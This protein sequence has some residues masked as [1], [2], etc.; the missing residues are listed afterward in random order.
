MK[1]QK[2]S[3]RK[4]GDPNYEK[5]VKWVLIVPQ[6]RIEQLGWK[7]GMELKEEIRKNSLHIT[8]FALNELNNHQESILF[9]EFKKSI[10]NILERHPAGLTWSQIRDKLNLPQKYPNNKWVRKLE[11]EI[12]LRRIRKGSELFW[13]SEY[14]IMYT[15]GYEG[16]D[17]QKFVKKLKDSNIQQLIDVREI[18]L[19]R[20]NGFSKSLLKM[21]LNNAGIRYEH[22][23]NLGSPKNIRHELK[24][25]SMNEADY[26]KFFREYKRH[27]HDEDVLN[28]ISIIEG[29]ARRKKS[30][31]MCFEKDY[32]TC[33]RTI[34][35]DELNKRGW[36]INN[37]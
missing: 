31:M 9:E 15:I 3:S 18:A 28:N 33:H 2:Q 17:I 12:G 16:Y 8:P 24:A 22:L 36:K 10:K 19:S 20:K 14:A 26:K 13:S 34:V 4:K 11:Q 1:L 21:A 5:Y 32:K 37:L 35:A 6:D 29:L 30:V 23:K 7:E 25:S 27:I